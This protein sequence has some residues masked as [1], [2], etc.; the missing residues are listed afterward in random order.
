MQKGGAKFRE[1]QIQIFRTRLAFRSCMQRTLKKNDAGITFEMLQILN[2]LWTEQGITQQVL[3]E[4]SAK[5]KACLSNLVGNL[6]KNGYVYR[7]EALADRRNKQVFLT[8]AGAR[9]EKH[10]RPIL[11]EVYAQAEQIFGLEQIQT[12]LSDL[13]KMQHVLEDL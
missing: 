5:N 1:L 6:E 9:L 12:T 3:A 2:C 4:R 8:P 13:T 11:N 7:Q 10:I